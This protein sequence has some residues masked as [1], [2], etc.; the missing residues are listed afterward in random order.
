[1]SI[2]AS[3]G[4]TKHPEQLSLLGVFLLI[5]RFREAGLCRMSLNYRALE[6]LVQLPPIN[7]ILQVFDGLARHIPSPL[8]GHT[9]P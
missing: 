4:C 8:L 3:F 9:E 7:M 6:L 5:M 1:M 2:E